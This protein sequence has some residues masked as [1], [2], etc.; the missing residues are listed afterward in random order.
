MALIVP[1][2]ETVGDSAL[3]DSIIDRSI[4]EL[5]DN[6]ITTLQPYA[7]AACSSLKKCVFGEL[8]EVLNYSFAG[9]EALDTLDIYSFVEFDASALQGLS[10]LKTLI[11]RSSTMCDASSGALLSYT[12]IAEGT[13]YI[14]VPRALVDSYKHD[15]VWGS[16]A[17]Q[18]RAI[19]D[20]PSVCSTAG[21]M[22]IQVGNGNE[23]FNGV[24]SADGLFVGCGSTIP[25]KGAYYSDDGKVWTKSSTSLSGNCVT[26]DDGLWVI[27]GSSSGLFYSENGKTWTQ[28]N[29]TSGTFYYVTH[30]TG[31]WVAGGS[32]GIYYSDD[33]KTWTLSN[34]TANNQ[35]GRAV[36][37]NGLWVAGGSSG[38][39]YSEDGKVWAQSDV[40]AVSGGYITSVAYANGM[41]VAGSYATSGSYGL[42]YSED[43]K[44]WTLAVSKVACNDV[45]F[46]S[47]IWVACFKGSIRYSTDGKAWTTGITGD[48]FSSATIDNGVL[49]VASTTGLYYSVDGEVWERSNIVS[50]SFK[51]ITCENG[52]WVVATSNGKGLYYSE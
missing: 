22:W 23:R 18:I 17:D 30:Q 2:V 7:L 43:G 51:P 41:W 29:I 36:Y 42:Y 10:G 20:Y 5:Q 15:F 25:S 46:F 45:I 12:P 52:V 16:Y 14:Y 27:G 9:D 3:T 39:Y 49:V 26:H 33:G 13:G 1:S 31:L 38:L 40:T 47:G 37:A 44:A 21:K 35:R 24:A 50:G 32:T 6:V 28:S 48:T 4:T 34:I 19:E 8:S 11:L